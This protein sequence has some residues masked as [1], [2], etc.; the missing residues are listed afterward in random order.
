VTSEGE[1]VRSDSE[2]LE[3]LETN[4]GFTQP[5]RWIPY[6]RT[7]DFKRVRATK[8]DSCPDCGEVH[9]KTIGQY[10]YYS[11]LQSLKVC[12]G[13][14]LLYSDT[15]I[16][17]DILRAH[18]ER[19][20]INEDYFTTQRKGIFEQIV[21]EVASRAP[22][23]GTILDVGGA[24]GHLMAL[25]S[26]RRPDLKITLN[27]LSRSKCDWA[28]SHYGLRT[29]CGSETELLLCRE[30]FDVITAIDVLYY[31]SNISQM[32]SALTLLLKPQGTL[33]LRVP[34][35]WLAVV[36]H[37]GVLNAMTTADARQMRTRIQHFNAEHL[38]VFS[39]KYLKKRLAS[40]GVASV[41]ILPSALLAHGDRF[42]GFLKFY[43]TIAKAVHFL[44]VE[45]TVITPG[46]L[47]VAAK[48]EDR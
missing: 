46:M 32:W 45:R 31:A 3:I 27:D 48:V 24:K 30:R 9:A 33:I 12:R 16:S 14:H 8:I 26:R 44:S 21:G 28:E 39:R 18:F 20:Y 36:L 29:I 47:V 41:K 6:A 13:C 4:Q 34:N 43:Y 40:L 38:Y 22:A 5:Q 1:G 42:G 17:S 7:H 25:L 23:G 37:E 35:N 2:W 10:I 11:S 19:S 15:R